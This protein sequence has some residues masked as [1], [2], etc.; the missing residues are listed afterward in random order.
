MPQSHDPNIDIALERALAGSATPEELILL[1][2]WAERAG[3]SAEDQARIPHHLLPRIE[4]SRMLAWEDVASQI[5]GAGG[6]S[7]ANPLKSNV[8]S[9]KERSFETVESGNAARIHHTSAPLPSVWR[10]AAR[11]LRSITMGAAVVAVVG[12]TWMSLR[13]RPA[14]AEQRYTTGVGQRVM[15]VLPDGSRMTLAPQTVVR[16]ASSFGKAT[17]TVSV[18]GEAH[19]DITSAS[20]APFIVQ[21]GAVQTRVLGTRFVVKAYRDDGD[22]RVAV[23]R[24]KVSVGRAERKSAVVTAGRAA[25]ITD[26]GIVVSVSTDVS[27]YTDWMNGQLTFRSAPLPDALATLSRWYGV[28]FRVADSSL[29]SSRVTGVL[30]YGSLEDMLKTVQDMLDVSLTYE[31]HGDGALLVTLHSARAETPVRPR[32]E[33]PFSPPTA[34]GR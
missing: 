34:L 28:Q 13:G 5:A 32:R 2:A 20:G 7:A 11:Q 1:R 19:F 24:G 29:V 4:G 22:V 18:L 23:E 10:R 33:R 6:T 12:V 31:R 16:V 15:Y 3:A 14:P 21:T 26:T 17:R 27:E 9:R 8:R 30:P 25:L